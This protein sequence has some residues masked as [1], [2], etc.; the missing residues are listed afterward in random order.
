MLVKSSPPQQDAVVEAGTADF[1]AFE[2]ALY[3]W[4]ILAS[5]FGGVDDFWFYIEFKLRFH[6]SVVI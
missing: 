5:C 4:A 6:S 2:Q 1:S 3:H